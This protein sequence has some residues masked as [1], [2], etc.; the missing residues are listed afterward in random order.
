MECIALAGG[1][2]SFPELNREQFFVVNARNETFLETLM[3]YGNRYQTDKAAAV[4]SLFGGENVV[5]IA[6]PEILPA[7]R[8]G[9]LERLNKERELIGIY[10]SAHPLDEYA[11]V[12]N[13]VCNTRMI[14]LDDKSALAGREITMRADWDDIR[15]NVMRQL[16]EQ[17]FALGSQCA[18]MLCLTEDHHIEETNTWGDTF[19]GVCR[20]EG[21]NVL[22]EMLMEIRADL[23][24]HIEFKN[25]S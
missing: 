21:L 12:L 24:S 9:D 23:L 5:D 10:L 19:W 1:F 22:G 17:K 3:R 13:H 15:V 16:L 8:W 14:E 7:E 11:I 25:W 2:D 6:T 4:N 18:H 20:G